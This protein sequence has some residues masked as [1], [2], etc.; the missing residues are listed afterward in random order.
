MTSQAAQCPFHDPTAS[1]TATTTPVPQATQSASAGS[2]YPVAD[3]LD[4]ESLAADPYA[5]YARLREES[6][7]P[8]FRNCR[9]SW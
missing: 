3:W 2:D 7:W 1:K 6:P 9:G 5:A 4:V 8:G